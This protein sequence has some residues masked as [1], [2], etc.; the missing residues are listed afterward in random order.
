MS[1]ATEIAVVDMAAEILYAWHTNEGIDPADSYHSQRALR[2]AREVMP[3]VMVFAGEW[4]TQATY[5]RQLAAM[6][7]VLRQMLAHH[8]AQLPSEACD[9]YGGGCGCP[10]CQAALAALGVKP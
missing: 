3:R 8:R 2:H 1:N 9:L 10:L 6:A 4:D 5:E 7:D